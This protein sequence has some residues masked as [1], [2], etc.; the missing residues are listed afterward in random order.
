MFNR[1]LTF[2]GND[3]SKE[4]PAEAERLASILVKWCGV[5][6]VSFFATCFVSAAYT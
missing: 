2:E 5:E 3:I 1:S 6:N 4:Q